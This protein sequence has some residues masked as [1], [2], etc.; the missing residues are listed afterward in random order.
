VC[1]ALGRTN[2]THKDHKAEK[3]HAM[4]CLDGK[5]GNHGCDAYVLDGV[6]CVVGICFTDASRQCECYKKN[7]I[8]RSIH[9]DY[10]KQSNSSS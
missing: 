5:C 2:T 9:P 4:S 10:A 3:M 8:A 1:S 6:C 7:M